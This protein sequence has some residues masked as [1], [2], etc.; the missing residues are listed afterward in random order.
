MCYSWW[1]LIISY[2][3]LDLYMYYI[4]YIYLHIYLYIR[5][6]VLHVCTCTPS[7]QL[8]TYTTYAHTHI[9]HMYF[10]Q[11]TSHSYQL[12]E[13]KHEQ[14]VENRLQPAHLVALELGPTRTI[15]RVRIESARMTPKY[16]TCLDT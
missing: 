16:W 3:I 2:F 14:K 10:L 6:C 11:T 15:T 12:P 7:H 9:S 1:P 4:F 8:F 13:T 5:V